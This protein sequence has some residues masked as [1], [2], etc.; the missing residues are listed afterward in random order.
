MP[1]GSLGTDVDPHAPV[2]TIVGITVEGATFAVVHHAEGWVMF[3][4][5]CPHARCSFV[6]DGGEVADGTVLVCA[7]HGSE[8]DL[9]DGTV[10]A[11][12]ATQ[13]L[14]LS[15]LTVEGDRLTAT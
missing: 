11:G 6:H 8:F 14:A 7:C 10:L 3:D 1:G 2:G 4:D 15:P 9:R 5:R 12:P 13:A